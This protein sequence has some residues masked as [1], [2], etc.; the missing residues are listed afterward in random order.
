[1]IVFQELNLD[2]VKE[3]LKI[4]CHIYILM[5]NVIV[6]RKINMKMKSFAP[7][8]KETKHSRLSCWFITYSIRI[9]NLDGSKCQK[10]PLEVFCEQRCSLKCRKIHRKLLCLR[11]Q[12]WILQNFATP[13]SQN[14]SGR[15]LLKC[16]HFNNEA[17]DMACI[18][19]RV[20][21]ALLWLKSQSAREPSHHPVF[22]EIC[23]VIS[24][25]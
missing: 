6:L 7:T 16:G 10:Q 1:M 20:L 3:I 25:R 19:C 13:L 14:N 12:L 22:M 9:E 4:R 2:S 11:K 24:H 18:C 15:L 8:Y 5:K 23:R 17:R 21:D